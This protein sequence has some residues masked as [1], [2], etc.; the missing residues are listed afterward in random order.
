MATKAV[1]IEAVG[2]LTAD[3]FLG[4]SKR[5]I[6]W[7][8]LVTDILSDKDT[9]FVGTNNKLRESYVLLELKEIQEKLTTETSRNRIIWHFNPLLSPHFGGS[10][11]LP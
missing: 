11:R 8:G 10:E 5:F 4:A 7:R 3:L 9:N 2:D 6:G 1:H